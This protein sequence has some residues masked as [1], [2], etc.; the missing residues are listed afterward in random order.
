M[1]A[2]TILIVIFVGI[3]L[4]LLGLWAY[5]RSTPPKEKGKTRD[6]AEHWGVQISAPAGERACPQ[7]RELLGKEFSIAE[8]PML[9]LPDCPFPHQCE[10]RYIRLVDRRRED[11]RSA[12]DRRLKGER[13]EKDNPPRRSGKDRRK[14]VDWF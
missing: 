12:Q 5:R 7:V 13:L 11:R 9:P 8:R 1:G 6:Q 2:S 4:V 10:C 3:A 14:R